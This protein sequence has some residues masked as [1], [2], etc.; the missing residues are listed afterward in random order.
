MHDGRHELSHLNW[1]LVR[2]GVSLRFLKL[3]RLVRYAVS[4]YVWY[5]RGKIQLIASPVN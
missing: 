1:V 2:Q 3:I 5:F 4:G